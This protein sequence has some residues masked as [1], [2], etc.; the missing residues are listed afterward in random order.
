MSNGFK[1]PYQL[2]TDR[3]LQGLE[4]GV[5]GWVK[6]WNSEGPVAA[7]RPMNFSNATI[8]RG[9]NT[10]MLHVACIERGWPVPAFATFNQ[11]RKL[12]GAVSKGSKGEHV[13]FKSQV[14][15][16]PR[17]PEEESRV[18]AN[19]K[20]KRTVLKGYTVFNISQVDGISVDIPNV[21]MPSDL[22]SDL[23]DL[24]QLVGVKLSHGGDKAFY[25]IDDD[26]ITLPVPNDFHSLDHYKA[27]AFHEVG[28]ATGHGSRL[29][30]QFGRKFGDDA[31]AFEELVAE[32]SAAF[33][34][35][36]FGV[37]GEL[38]HPEY[39]GNWIRIL[40]GDMRAF[41]GAAAEAQRAM[42]WIRERAADP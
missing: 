41:Y 33:L 4:Q 40:K 38:R 27:T 8:Y 10:I 42:D 28:H 13:F 1:S 6:P 15:S 12:K 36:E 34:A 29:N 32:L 22:P 39:I 18:G 37:K 20:I 19:G 9:V 2:I 16:D 25:S 14:E 23:L 17:S 24:T 26:K 3:I 30:R 35:M 21:A 31:Y 7:T 11:I 5:A